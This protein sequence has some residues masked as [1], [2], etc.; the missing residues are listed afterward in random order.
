MN[1]GFRE[2]LDQ[3]WNWRTGT[4]GEGNPVYETLQYPFMK[5]DLSTNENLSENHETDSGTCD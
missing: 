3:T 2:V 1:S 5:R 4:D